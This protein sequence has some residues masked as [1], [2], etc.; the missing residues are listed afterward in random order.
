MARGRRKGPP[1]GIATQ[2][3]LWYSKR[4]TSRGKRAPINW[5]A[6]G[7]ASGFYTCVAIASKHMTTKQAK[8]YCSNRSVQ[9]TGRRS[10]SGNRRGGR[11]K[12][13]HR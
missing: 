11:R 6:H 4:G 5:A 2:G 12:A 7:K 3:K 8:G 9:A 10:G 1:G 13:S